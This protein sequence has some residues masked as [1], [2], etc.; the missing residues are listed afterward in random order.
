[1]IIFYDDP[2]Y[3][4]CRLTIM[5]LTTRNDDVYKS[6]QN[7]KKLNLKFSIFNLIVAFF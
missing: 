6:D 7:N 5:S 3:R 2:N 1:M 4:N